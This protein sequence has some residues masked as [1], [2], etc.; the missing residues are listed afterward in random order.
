MAKS[1]KVKRATSP[2]LLDSK[3]EWQLRWSL[4]G[5]PTLLWL[6]GLLLIVPAMC[7]VLFYF[8]LQWDGW[9]W[10]VAYLV[11]SA[12]LLLILKRSQPYFPAFSRMAGWWVAVYAL[13]GVA[14]TLGAWRVLLRPLIQVQLV[15]E[16]SDW[17]GIQYVQ[18]Q[19]PMLYYDQTKTN[20]QGHLSKKTYSVDMRFRV[21]M[22][23]NG[24]VY[25]DVH[26]NGDWD[27][28]EN[29]S[30]H[31][32]IQDAFVTSSRQRFAG[33]DFAYAHFYKVEAAPPERGG[34]R[35]QAY[36]QPYFVSF[37]DHRRTKIGIAAVAY[38]ALLLSWYL[39]VRFAS[40]DRRRYEK[41]QQSNP[42]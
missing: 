31:E 3:T 42:R 24:W 23:V 38:G 8:K 4:V 40:F 11:A 16:I 30:L 25:L 41:A 10:A 17:R 6:L 26:Y 27:Q 34:Y 20:L 28:T 12:C 9:L 37:A 29:E 1:P 21:P 32:Q 5:R 7:E 2:R 13:F 15:D 19:Q 14:M 39:V 22:D 33:T 18:V 35:N 36:L